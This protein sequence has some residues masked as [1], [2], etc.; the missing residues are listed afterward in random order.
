LQVSIKTGW[1]ALE[2]LSTDWENIRSTFNGSIVEPDAT[3]S[4]VWSH[5]LS[6]T[7]LRDA[8][9]MTFVA[10]DSEEEI[11]GLYPV[12]RHG[13]GFG[14][15]K[16]RETRAIT[17][18]YSGRC[19]VCATN[20]ERNTVS[21]LLNYLHD[22]NETDVTI[23]TVTEHSAT[24]RALV[25]LATQRQ[26]RIRCIAESESPYIVMDERWDE[27]LAKLPKKMRWTI[28]KSE[29]D[30]RSIGALDYRIF[31]SGTAT[32]DLLHAIYEIERKSWKEESGTSITAHS[33]QQAFY[34]SLIPRAAE[35]GVLSGHVIYIDDAPIAYI[36]GI[37]TEDGV[38]LDLKESFDNEY[39]KYSPG[40]VL[41]RFAFDYLMSSGVVAYDF[42][43]VCEPYKMRW[44]DRTYRR[45]TF[46]IYSRTFQ[47]TLAYA[48]ALLGNRSKPVTDI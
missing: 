3:C 10:S 38:F 11:I 17:E 48:R 40:H 26:A 18:A 42:M 13:T 14:P 35:K 16:R 29:R 20:N 45:L 41:K 15:I 7:L 47:G 37:R 39:L 5:A 2:D 4:P 32:Q 36:L 21:A 24:H 28:K 22:S 33:E 8:E 6:Q 30:L 34:E 19:G 46:T 9:V 43:G 27:F 1:K 31:E 44:T 25:E 12:S 23:L